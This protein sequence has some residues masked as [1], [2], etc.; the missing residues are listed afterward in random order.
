MTSPSGLQAG[1]I[2]VGVFLILVLASALG[3]GR[4]NRERMFTPAELDE[5]R[6]RKETERTALLDAKIEKLQS[7][8]RRHLQ[9]KA[10]LTERKET[11]EYMQQSENEWDTRGRH[12]YGQAWDT[13]IDG[14]M[15]IKDL[16][17]LSEEELRDI[18]IAAAN[19]VRAQAAA[20]QLDAPDEEDGSHRGTELIT[21]RAYRN[22]SRSYQSRGS[23]GSRRR[24]TSSQ[25]P[26]FLELR[27]WQELPTSLPRA[28]SSKAT[29]TWPYPHSGGPGYPQAP[30]PNGAA[31][32]PPLPLPSGI[33][34]QAP[35][36]RNPRPPA[37][38]PP[39]K[40]PVESLPLIKP[41]QVAPHST[42][43]QLGA[44]KGEAASNGVLTRLA[45]QEP[46]I[47]PLL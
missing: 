10:Q 39:T 20:R 8:R 32:P 1:I 15:P 25:D 24:G 9:I 36:L 45:L 6:I 29:G 5:I 40:P 33:T 44:G 35:G 30:S 21:A 7:Q 34:M 38:P 26:R 18:R 27:G 16:M 47:A 3:C 22:T 23:S 31:P 19:R 14:N 17:R 2:I 42:Q 37:L 4:S 28:A 13:E 12:I 41:G 43:K 11:H 46:R